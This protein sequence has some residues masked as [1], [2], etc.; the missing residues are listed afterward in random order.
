MQVVAEVRVIVLLVALDHTE[1]GEE[2]LRARLPGFKPLLR[3]LHHS[4]PQF[5]HLKAKTV[6]GH[7]SQGCS[8]DSMSQEYRQA[9]RTGI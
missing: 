4:V 8:E 3:L 7:T 6:L 2:W 1:S 9:V 5:P